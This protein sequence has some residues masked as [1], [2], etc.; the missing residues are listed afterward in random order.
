SWAKAIVGRNNRSSAPTFQRAQRDR[1]QTPT[2]KLQKGSKGKIPNNCFAPARGDLR[3][4]FRNGARLCRRPAAADERSSNAANSRRAA[5][6]RGRHSRAPGTL[7]RALKLSASSF[8]G[9]WRLGAGAFLLNVP[10]V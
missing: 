4:C 3:A 10:P 5:A 6:G 8:S 1:L 9:A 2:T 7:S